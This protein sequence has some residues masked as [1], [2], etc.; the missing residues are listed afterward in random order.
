MGANQH[1]KI[2]NY[3]RNHGEISQREAYFM[4]IGR[5][6]SRIHDLKNQGH[7]IITEMREATNADGSKTHVA[8]YHLLG[9]DKKEE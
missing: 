9:E 4:G 3:L 2:L 5:L 8:F 7:C 1:Q 6:A